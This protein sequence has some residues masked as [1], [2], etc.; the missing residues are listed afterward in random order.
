MK[1]PGR[2]K[3]KGKKTWAPAAMLGV[4]DRKPGFRHR[5][6]NKDP[7]NL[8]RK[9]AE[10]W[11]MADSTTGSEHEH[12]GQ[13][14]DGKPL[15]SITEYRELVLMAVPEDIAKSRDDYFRE[16][17]EKQTAGL[18]KSLQSDIDA[19]GVSGTEATYGKVVIE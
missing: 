1:K 9:Q 11:I 18:K 2:P 8:Q 19:T 17:T 4:V 16:K 14:E 15:T 7:M 10:G 13:V 5:W 3:K 6:V 12:P